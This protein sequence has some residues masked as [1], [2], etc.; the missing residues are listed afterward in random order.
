MIAGEAF[1]IDVE[2]QQLALDPPVVEGVDLRRAQAE[3]MSEL[4]VGGEDR[5][6]PAEEALAQHATE[7]GVEL[8]QAVVGANTLAVGRIRHEQATASGMH[9]RELLELAALRV[10]DA[11]QSGALD[12]GHSRAHGGRIVIVGTQ[13]RER[14]RDAALASGARLLEESKP[15]GAIVLDPAFEAPVCSCSPVRCPPRVRLD[16]ESLSALGSRGHRPHRCAATA[17]AG[18]GGDSP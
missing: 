9:R 13:G 15:G 4:G 5:R 8:G 11:A 6:M 1:P 17:R 16:G 10:H 7:P 12:V 2:V 3:L 18:C 14:L